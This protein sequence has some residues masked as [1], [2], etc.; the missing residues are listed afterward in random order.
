M[1]TTF[2]RTLVGSLFVVSGL[3]KSN[4]AL[5]FMYKL[6]EY[7]EPGAMNMEFLIPYA[8]EIAIFVC[9]GEILLGVALL[10]GA[11]PK[12][13]SVLTTGMMLFFTWL[14]WY[15]ATCDPFGMKEI[16]GPDGAL[17]T[18]A[19]QCVLECGCFGNAIPLT[20]IQSFYKDLVL[21]VFVLPI[22]IAA[23]RNKITLNDSRKS[24]IIYTGALVMTFLFG[25]L[26]LDW[27]FPTLY[28]IFLLFAGEAVRRR[29]SHP[30]VEW[31]MA[32]AIVI[33]IALVQIKTLN[34]LPLKDYRP[35]AVGEDIIQN[36]MSAE[37]LG[38]DGPVYAT[39]YIFKNVSSG[40]DTIVLSTDYLKVY[41]DSIFKS[42]YEIVT[43]DGAEVQLKDG[44]EPRILD[45]QMIDEMGEDVVDSALSGS[46]YTFLHIS[47]DLEGSEGH[48]QSDFN[49]L[50]TSALK[51]GHAFYG[52]TN[53]GYD[54]NE[55]FRHDHQA[56]YQFLTCDQTELKIVIR[57]NP[58]LVL[59]KGAEVIEKWA[60]RDIPSYDELQDLIK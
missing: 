5:G 27:N 43:Y 39:E 25:Y 4:D 41:S 47:K 1:T 40:A 18:I 17:I 52:L 34:H 60:W 29:I 57:S 26:M 53:V 7:F 15:T 19:N 59:L 42:T 12:L 28:L 48:A 37:E 14:T 23:F 56:P 30:K 51:E 32:G 8:L 31:I 46:G 10:I 22:L 9:I 11:L 49:A 3:I 45:F 35:Y 21:L 38:V 13:V 6:E 20:A 33:V 2:S 58:G 54:G 50:A 24:L 44:Y 55:N 36:R 16:M